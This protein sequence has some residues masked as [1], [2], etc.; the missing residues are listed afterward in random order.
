L[1]KA[2][3]RVSVHCHWCHDGIVSGIVTVCHQAFWYINICKIKKIVYRVSHHSITHL[4]E[5]WFWWNLHRM[6]PCGVTPGASRG[7]WKWP[8]PFGNY[9]TVASWLQRVHCPPHAL[10][11]RQTAANIGAGRHRTEVPM[12]NWANGRQRVIIPR[13]WPHKTRKHPTGTLLDKLSIWDISN[14]LY[15]WKQRRLLIAPS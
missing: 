6:W 14:Q 12:D 11:S 2:D 8:L 13:S 3:N 5:H 15:E 10:A 7:V 9:L 1:L 4:L